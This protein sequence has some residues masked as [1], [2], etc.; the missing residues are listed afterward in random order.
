ME[1]KTN[2]FVSHD[3]QVSLFESDTATDTGTIVAYALVAPVK[4]R[5]Y[6][7]AVPVPAS[8][9]PV[10]LEVNKEVV[11]AVPAYTGGRQP[12]W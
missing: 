9:E 1:L 4:G 10:E 3:G 11:G 12:E 5:K 2:Y 7:R 6:I 8:G